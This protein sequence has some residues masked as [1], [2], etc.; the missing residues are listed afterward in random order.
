MFD[1][2][3]VST[4][5]RRRSRTAKFFVCTSITYLVVVASAFALSILVEVPELAGTS[6]LESLI[7]LSLRPGLQPYRPVSTHRDDVRIPREDPGSVLKHDDTNGHQQIGLL[8][9]KLPMDLDLVASDGIPNR[10]PSG[11]PHSL[12]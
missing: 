1:K 2:L 3:V 12:G 7:P 8:R 11:I 10:D 6:D 4:A 9:M 5:G